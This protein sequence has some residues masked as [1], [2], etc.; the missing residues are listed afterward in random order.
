MDWHSSETDESK[1]R[2]QQA[3]LS[4]DYTL[5]PVGQNSEYAHKPP[6]MEVG[7]LLT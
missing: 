6:D 7:H 3:L 2:Y 1:Q 4:S 5:A